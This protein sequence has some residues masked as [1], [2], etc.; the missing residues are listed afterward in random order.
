MSLRKILIAVFLGAVTMGTEAQGQS[1]SASLASFY[2]LAPISVQE[3]PPTPEELYSDYLPPIGVY[4]PLSPLDIDWGTVNLIGQ[5]VVEIIKAG[6]PVVNVRRDGVAVLPFGVTAWSQLGGWQLP[7][8]KVYRVTATNYMNIAVVDLRLKVSASYGGGLDGR[9]KFLAN[10]VVVPTSIQVMWGFSCDVWS[11]H[12]APV[13]MGTQADP[14]AGLGFD[15][16]YRYGSL[17]SETTGAQDY[18]VSGDGE[19]KEL[20]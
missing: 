9:G 18:F 11:E 16:R 19:I 12:H 17:L 1:P 13:N 7:V 15:L 6:R 20:N 4:P 10:V 3:V 14:V 8:T 5:K 2:S